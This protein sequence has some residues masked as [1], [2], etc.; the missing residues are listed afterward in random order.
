MQKT[1][2]T[3]FSLQHLLTTLE[4]IRI[5]MQDLMLRSLLLANS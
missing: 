4:S 5:S 3:I 1:S 2:E